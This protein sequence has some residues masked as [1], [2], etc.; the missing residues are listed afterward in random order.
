[1]R[2]AKAN[3]AG[4]EEEKHEAKAD[5]A[6]AEEE[7]HKEKAAAAGADEKK[8]EGTAKAWT[9]K[10]GKISENLKEL[11]ETMSRCETSPTCGSGVKALVPEIAEKYKAAMK[12]RGC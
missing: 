3:A 4:A 8:H 6:E 1:M 10:C 9:K 5:A 2:E 7:N 11:E 12:E